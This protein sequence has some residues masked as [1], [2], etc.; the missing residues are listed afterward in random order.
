MGAL[1]TAKYQ[2]EHGKKGILR[3]LEVVFAIMISFIFLLYVMPQQTFKQEEKPSIIPYLLNDY[4]FRNA[5]SS[6]NITKMNE[7][8][9][10]RMNILYPDYNFTVS[11]S[12]DPNY[13]LNLNHK[14]VYS[15]S[16]FIIGNITS[17]RNHVV[18]IYYWRKGE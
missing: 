13:I 5:V 15:E 4:E 11:I 17:E 1:R 16:L 8:I 18:R 6:N 9:S 2:L 14:T 7:R 12:S 10:Q 3:T